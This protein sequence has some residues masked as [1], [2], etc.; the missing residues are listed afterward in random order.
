MKHPK[1]VE[2]IEAICLQLQTRK[3]ALKPTKSNTKLY[4]MC[5]KT[6]QFENNVTQ[7]WIISPNLKGKNK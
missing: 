2:A 7:M 6:T 3:N 4:V 5:F 1:G